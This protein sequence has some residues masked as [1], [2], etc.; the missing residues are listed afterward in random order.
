M[1]DFDT[2][3]MVPYLTPDLTPREKMVLRG[4]ANLLLSEKANEFVRQIVQLGR[5]PS[6]AYERA[7]SVLDTDT[8]EW[9][10]PDH[11]AYQS[12]LLLRNPDVL[13]RVKE[14]REAIKM[15][16]TIER[17]ELILTLKGIALDPSLK[18][19]DRIAASAQLTRMEGLNKEQDVAPGG[20]IVIQLPFTPQTLVSAP[21]IKI[22]EGETLDN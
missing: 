3:H 8:G 13:E 22:V 15:F 9:V 1:A 10:K 16:G 2:E 17:E 12:A 6:E 19:A 21:A 4:D 7:F 18:P 20:T 11:C 5:L 14:E